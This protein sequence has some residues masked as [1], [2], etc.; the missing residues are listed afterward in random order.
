MFSDIGL[1]T[2]Q[3]NKQL[4]VWVFYEKQKLTNKIDQRNFLMKNYQKK[5][6]SKTENLI[7]PRK[8]I[9]SFKQKITV[10]DDIFGDDMRL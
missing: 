9:T 5:K 2:K 6:K 4:D 3:K 1:R 10:A 7:F 8:Q